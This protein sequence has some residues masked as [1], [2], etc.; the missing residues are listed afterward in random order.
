MKT[1][2]IAYSHSGNNGFL[3]KLLQQKLNADLQFIHEKKHKGT[4]SILLDITLNRIPEIDADFTVDPESH[5][6]FIA[7][8]WA[9]KIATPLKAFLEREATNI[10]NYSF[11]TV[12]GVQGQAEKLEEE[13]T[14]IVGRKPAM[15]MDL[16]VVR[17]MDCKPDS[18]A[19]QAFRISEDD[20]HLFQD[21]INH[22]TGAIRSSQFALAQ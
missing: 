13:L 20:L 6:V 21:E 9:S 18:K 5:V 2:V 12:C 15:L 8:I 22:F 7:P 3:A 4:F 19:L 10:G 14:A 11:A 1:T 16:A 17:L